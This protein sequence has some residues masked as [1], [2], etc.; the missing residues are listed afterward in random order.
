M[1]GIQPTRIQMKGREYSY[2]TANKING[3]INGKYSIETI[4][5]K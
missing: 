1:K 2:C 3:G 5:R 4:S